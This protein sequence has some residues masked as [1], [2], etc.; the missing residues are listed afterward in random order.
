MSNIP[1]INPP[2]KEHLGFCWHHQFTIPLLFD[3]CLSLLQKVCA[4]WAK[5]NDVIDALNKF[6]D[7][8]NAW[9]KSVED[10]LKDLYAKYTALEARVSKNEQDIDNIKQQLQSIT[11]ELNNIKQNISNIMS[12]LDNIE[13]RL[14]NIEN[15]LT[16][17]EGDITNIK[18]RLS[19]IEGDIT[20]IRQSISNI[21]ESIEILESDLTAL[22]GRVKKLEDLLKNLNI[23]PPIDI[24][25]ATDDAFASGLWVNWWNWLKS[26][27]SFK[28]AAP[29]ERW[30]YA[31]N[32]VWWDTTTHLPRYFQ[33][34]RISQPLTLCKLP[35]VAV[36]KG[37]FDHMPTLEDL[38]ATSPR[39][40]D[41]AFTA[42][43]GFFDFALTAPFGYTMDEIK[44]QTSYIPFLPERSILYTSSGS[45]TTV[46][47]INCG[48]RLQVPN[49]GTAAK[50][51]VSTET[52]VLGVCPDS[53][54][55]SSATKW[56][57]YIYAVAEN[58]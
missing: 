16:N 17:I 49:E 26:K 18:Q 10:S 42:G 44:F 45:I 22:E 51:C 36:C 15:R 48:V 13:N 28:T 11:G 30:A 33:L 23:I 19:T 6:N 41:N 9:A 34:G 38:Q 7:E 58:G 21:N 24:Y 20:N 47:N 32:V 2:D 56:D 39:Y 43:N 46:K 12:R 50:L 14:T 4:L 27:L 57:M 25:N 55:V 3:D 54:P 53:V 1:I 35:F 8:F 29:V 40:N 31:A 37:V 5:L 52:L